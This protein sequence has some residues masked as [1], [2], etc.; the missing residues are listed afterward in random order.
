[1]PARRVNPHRV[2]LHR[3]YSVQELADCLGVH[4]NTVRHWQGAGLAAIDGNRPTL[5]DGKATRA[6]LLAR[7]TSRKRPCPPGTI[8]CFGCR[9]PRAPALGM[10]EFMPGKGAT[11]NLA[12]LCEACGTVMHRRANMAMIAAI[13][14]RLAVQIRQAP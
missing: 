4:K 5:F 12:A 2:K 9:E 6:F 1:M 7:Q 10:V 11:G 3:T 8:Y 14:P 13:M